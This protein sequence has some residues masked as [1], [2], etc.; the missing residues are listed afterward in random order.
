MN[1]LDN[2]DTFRLISLFADMAPIGPSL[3]AMTTAT[4]IKAKV[5]SIHKR[6]SAHVPNGIAA[7]EDIKN[8]LQSHKYNIIWNQ[9]TL[10]LHAIRLEPNDSY[11][12]THIRIDYTDVS[13]HVVAYGDPVSV[14]N[15]VQWVNK[16]FPKLGSLIYTAVDLDV[17][18]RISTTQ[19]YISATTDRIATG[20]FYPWLSISLAKYFREFMASSEPVL[21][22]FGPPGTGKS[23]FIRSLILSENYTA[24]LA[25]NQ[26]VVQ[27]PALLT[28]FYDSNA[29][30]LAYEDID[31]HL[32]SR[33]D[34]NILMSSLLNASDGV[35]GHPGKKIVLSTNLTTIDKIDPA[36]LRVGRCFDI[37]EFKPLTVAQSLNVFTS[38]ALTPKDL[39]SK[40]YWSLAEVLGT[41]NKSRQVIN[42]FSK[43]VGFN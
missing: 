34:G 21:V 14:D 11:V 10:L 1:A 23:T 15:F 22:L 13:V 18:N 9:H 20:A 38:L 30:I 41:E 17:H 37:L 7:V 36:L 32:G 19:S 33:E 40:H 4:R 28:E 42:R 5:D 24:M 3:D 26:K 31:N 8:W 35:V 27:S 29:K 43:R 16:K 25:Y 6:V 12:D 2:L 39:S